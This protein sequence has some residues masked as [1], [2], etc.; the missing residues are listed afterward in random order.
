LARHKSGQNII[1][2]VEIRSRKI[3]LACLHNSTDSAMNNLHSC[4][5]RTRRFIIYDSAVKEEV[6]S[7]T[8][9]L[10]KRW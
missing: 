9:I 8:L 2:H 10:R 5:P 6:S 1:G 7:L 3:Y 4:Y